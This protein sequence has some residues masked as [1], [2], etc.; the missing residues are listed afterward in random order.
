MGGTSSKP[1]SFED[2]WPKNSTAFSGQK[3][4]NHAYVAVLKSEKYAPLVPWKAFDTYDEAATFIKRKLT[5]YNLSERRPGAF[6]DS[7]YHDDPVAWVSVVSF[8]NLN[9]Y[10]LFFERARETSTEVELDDEPI[11][12]TPQ[13]SAPPSK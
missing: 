10:G 3:L 2:R 6:Y 11:E 4:E 13:P 9:K 12:G 7:M 8:A 5:F 1:P